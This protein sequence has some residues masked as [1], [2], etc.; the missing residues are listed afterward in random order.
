MNKLYVSIFF[1]A[2]TVAPCAYSMQPDQN[3][4]SL[5]A[6][7]TNLVRW[8]FTKVSALQNYALEHKTAAGVTALGAGAFYLGHKYNK[9][10]RDNVSSKVI[11]GS[12]TYAKNMREGDMTTWLGTGAVVGLAAAM[13]YHVPLIRSTINPTFGMTQHEAQA[14]I[15]LAKLRN[16]LATAK[17]KLKPIEEEY[18]RVERHAGIAQETVTRV[19]GNYVHGPHENAVVNWQLPDDV[20]QPVIAERNRTRVE[21]IKVGTLLHVAREDVTR[22]TQAVV[23]AVAQQAEQPN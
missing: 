22:L 19:E 5:K 18:V 2:L 14:F 15:R 13:Y 8:S 23:E 11:A 12:R 1:T 9:T 6:M 3:A 17:A 7:C 4:G 21:L 20:K 10:F 16:D